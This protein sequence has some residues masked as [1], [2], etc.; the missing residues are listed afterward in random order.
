MES[1][2]Y[3]IFLKAP[4]N[5]FDEFIS[6]CQKTFDKPA[7]TML[8]LRNRANKKIKGDKFEVFC[9]YYL[10]EVLGLENVWRLEDVP[11]EVLL[12]LNMKRRDMG[13]DI[14]GEKNGNYYAIQCKYKKYRDRKTVLTWKELSTFYALCLKTG[15]WERYI[16]MTNAD[17]TRQAVKTEK[18]LIFCKRHLQKISKDDWLKMCNVQ[19]HKIEDNKPVE[20]KITPEELRQKRLAFYDKK[21][22]L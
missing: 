2:L 20:N 3:N 5:L 9:V 1:E 13:I 6:E 17:Y 15:P 18:D 8:E 4:A 10:F 11:D 21:I 12:K 7:Q 14:I 16:V 19:G 22:D